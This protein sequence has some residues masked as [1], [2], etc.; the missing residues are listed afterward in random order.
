MWQSAHLLVTILLCISC[1]GIVL[2][3]L[4]PRSKDIYDKYKMIPM[5]DEE[6]SQNDRKREEKQQ[7]K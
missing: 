1:I 4:R 2:W 6:K 5:K 3:I 7:E